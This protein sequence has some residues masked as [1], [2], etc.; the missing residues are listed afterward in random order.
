MLKLAG[1]LR[2][3]SFPELMNVYREGNRIAAARDY[4]EEPEDYALELAQCFGLVPEPQSKF[5][6]ALALYRGESLWN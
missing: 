6:R 4:P 2:E 5:R 1:N 3:I